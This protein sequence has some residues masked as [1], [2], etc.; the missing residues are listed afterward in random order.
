E[1]E[2]Q[3]QQRYWLI[4]AMTSLLAGTLVLTLQGNLYIGGGLLVAG[5]L[6]VFAGRPNA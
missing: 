3:R 2:G 6:G 1:L 4:V 5:A